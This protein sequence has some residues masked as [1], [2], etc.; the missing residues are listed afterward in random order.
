MVNVGE[1]CER[2]NAYQN[3]TIMSIYWVLILFR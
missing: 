2:E 3:S 1:I